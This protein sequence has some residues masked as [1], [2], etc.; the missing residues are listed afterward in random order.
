[1]RIGICLGF[2]F[3]LLACGEAFTFDQILNG[4]ENRPDVDYYPDSISSTDTPAAGAPLTGS[5]TCTNRGSED[6]S[7]DITWECYSSYDKTLNGDDLYITGGTLSPLKAGVSQT[8]D[9]SGA[10]PLTDGQYYLILNLSAEDDVY[11]YNDRRVSSDYYTITGSGSSVDYAVTSVTNTGSTQG[12]SSLSGD[13]TFQNNGDT[14]GNYNVEWYA[15][16]SENS[17][18]GNG[19]LLIDT[20]SASALAPGAAST[21]SFTGTWPIDGGSFYLIVTVDANDEYET[22][23]SDNTASV[24]VALTP[25]DPRDVDYSCSSVTCTPAG[26]VYL[27]DVLSLESTFTNEG[28]DTGLFPLYW[29]LYVSSA[30]YSSIGDIKDNGTLINSG[31]E[32]P[33]TTGSSRTIAVSD[34]NGYE[35]TDGS[36][37]Y[38][39]Y[40]VIQS[41]EDT[42]SLN[43]W[44]SC[45][46][47]ANNT[48]RP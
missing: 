10:W 41:S 16:I 12:G 20:G 3:F 47:Y 19:D 31:Y 1:M 7:V 28:A 43:N 33:L 8:V 18:L 24:A 40:V 35:I 36:R 14:S 30:Y 37:S 13:F 42:N 26:N 39:F 44:A 34:Q 48:V 25:P 21:V 2:S 5:F 6:G 9:F 29:Y 27:G 17:S 11:S 15:Y 46:T 38:V 22:T 23:L 45:D 32:I 4:L